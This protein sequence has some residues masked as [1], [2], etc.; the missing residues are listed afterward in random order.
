MCC[1]N[2]KNIYTAGANCVRRTRQAMMLNRRSEGR[3]YGLCGTCARVWVLETT[4][5]GF[6][7]NLEGSSLRFG[8]GTP[9][10]PFRLLN[11]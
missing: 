8:Q 10:W 11:D 3:S 1:R 2:S 5:G 7:K 9:V 4:I 6:K